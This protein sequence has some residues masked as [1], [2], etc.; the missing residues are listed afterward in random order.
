VHKDIRYSY[1]QHTTLCI[2]AFGITMFS[3]H[4]A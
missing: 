1:T 3:I 2:M 4:D